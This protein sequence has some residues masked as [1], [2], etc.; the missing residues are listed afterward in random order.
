MLPRAQDCSSEAGAELCCSR[1]ASHLSWMFSW[2]VGRGRSCP[3]QLHTESFARYTPVGAA[4]PWRDLLS[5]FVGAFL[6]GYSATPHNVDTLSPATCPLPGKGSPQ[7][8][9]VIKTGPCVF[10]SR[11]PALISL[12]TFGFRLPEPTKFPLAGPS[13]FGCSWLQGEPVV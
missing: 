1:L 6:G 2:N 12:N 5:A 3:P 7:K 11:W 8:R 13:S 4:H 10:C 9:N